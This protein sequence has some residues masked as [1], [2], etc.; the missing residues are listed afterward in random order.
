[1]SDG[2]PDQFRDQLRR[3]VEIHRRLYREWPRLS[4]RYRDALG[5][6]TSPERWEQTFSASV[7]E[8]E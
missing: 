4:R 7:Q 8:H 1:M 6:L 3:T 5:D 2:D